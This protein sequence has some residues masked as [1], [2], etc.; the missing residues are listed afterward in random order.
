MR[1]LV[2][3]WTG[4]AYHLTLQYDGARHAFVLPIAG[5]HHALAACAAIATALVLGESAPEIAD[6]L[7]AFRGAERSLAV[8][9]TQAG[10]TVV[11]S[12]A[13]HPREISEDVT[14]ARWLTEGSVTAVLEPDGFARASAHAAELGTALGDA[15]TALLR[16]RWRSPWSEGW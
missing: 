7:T 5:R 13:R 15:D 16:G 4:D 2:P 11:D 6:C 12:R 10:I 14:A 8:L 3:R 1:I 9:G